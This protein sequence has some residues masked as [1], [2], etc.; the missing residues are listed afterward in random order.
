VFFLRERDHLVLAR[1]LLAEGKPEQARMLLERLLAA[2][3]AAGRTG[4]VIEILTLQALALWAR[5]KKEWAVTTLAQALASAEPEGYVRTF[6]DEGAEMAALLSKVLEVQQRGR[7]APDVPAYYLRK[8]LA[9]LERD[10][11]SAATPAGA[12]LR[13]PLSEREL[14]V[15]GL[16]ASGK[17]NQEI[18]SSLFVSLSTV[19]THINNL[20]RK[21]GTRSRTQAIARA[22]DLDLI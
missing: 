22:R 19:K 2:A 20:Y 16:V 9:A 3:E 14:E 11:S 5:G 12:E 10:A 13:E 17:S 7:L 4:S 18:A 8:L 15:L 6:V 21:L 1:L